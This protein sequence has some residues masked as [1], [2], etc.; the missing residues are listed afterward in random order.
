MSRFQRKRDMSMSRVQRK[1][2]MSMNRVQRKGDMSMS[3]VRRKNLAYLR[4][5]RYHLAAMG[6]RKRSGRGGRKKFS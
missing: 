4:K 3:R 5:S 6:Q 2:D 1:L